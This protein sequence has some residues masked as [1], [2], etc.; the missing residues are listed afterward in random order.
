[1]GDAQTFTCSLLAVLLAYA[2]GSIPWGALIAKFHGL[3]IRRYG[4][5]NIGATNVR[6][7]LGRDW[8]ILCFVLDFLKGLV[9]VGVA[10]WLERRYAVEP[11]LLPVFAA[12][13][14]VAGHVW[15]FTLEFKGGKGVA[16]A[17]GALIALAPWSVAV[18]LLGW[19]AVFRLARYVS[20]ASVC[21][22]VLVPVSALVERM[23]RGDTPGAPVVVLLVVL[24]AL[25]V[26]RHRSNLSRL[27]Q[28]TEYRFE[29]RV[30][31]RAAK[32]DEQDEDS[33]TQ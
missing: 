23:V 33:G 22:A 12:G 17:I 14:A 18:G 25:I 4:S 11:G 29:P 19:L 21:A 20:L 24:A 32:R 16:T 13:A 30:R 28:G 26:F 2:F 9:P 27:R 5:G 10:F 3:D 1:M 31:S 6:R 7:L 15:P 8:G